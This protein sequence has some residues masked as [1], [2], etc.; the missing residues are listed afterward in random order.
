MATA[1]TPA[2]PGPA[3]RPFAAVTPRRPRAR[4]G[5]RLLVVALRRLVLVAFALWSAFPIYWIATMSLK[6]AVDA[7]AYPPTWLFTP[8]LANYRTILA[9]GEVIAFFRN[10]LIVGLGA[11]A[12]AL[13]V[14]VPTAYVLARHEFKGRADYDFWVLSTRMAPPVATLVP[15]FIMYRELG[16][17]DT[18]VGLIVAHVAQNLAIV[19]WVMKG[20]FADLPAEL[21]E[22]GLVDGG[23]HWQA[24]R[25]IMLPLALPGIAATG[26]LAFL[27]SW[28][29]F[30]FALVLTDQAART[31]PVGLQGFIGYQEV[32]W[33]RLSA[34]ATVML[35]P[36]M[37][38]LLL[39]QRRIIRGLTFGAVRG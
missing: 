27:F 38:L 35:V 6:R 25:T 28:N 37:L 39:F 30:L 10:S 14:G 23:G 12:L 17:Y 15:F 18:H 4:S 22:A 2:R 36:V 31:A 32:E 19:I 13:L 7:I 26:I 24:F 8:T 11:T 5:R 20:F 3:S 21:E 9:E 34:A 1:A 29:E 33:G 16:L